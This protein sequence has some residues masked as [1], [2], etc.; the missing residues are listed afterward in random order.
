[1]SRPR[2]QGD[3]QMESK[4]IS[5]FLEKLGEDLIE[6]G[7]ITRSQL[8]Q[9]RQE[10]QESGENLGEV[11][12]R[13]GFSDQRKI[14]KYIGDGLDIPSIELTHYDIDPVAAETIE[15]SVAR[16]YRIIPMFEIE[17]VITI[18]MVDPFDIFAIEKMQGITGKIIEPVLATEKDVL[19]KIDLFWG[20]KNQLDELMD[21]LAVD[22]GSEKIIVPGDGDQDVVVD[23]RP[24]IKL[25]DSVFSDAVKK[26]ASD[27]H[28]EPESDLVRIRYRIDG[29]LQDISLVDYAY[30]AAMSTRV[31]YMAKMDIG[32]RRVPQDGKIHRSI[33][34]RKIDFRVST[35]PVVYGEKIVLRILDLKS[36]RVKLDDL[37]FDSE[38]LAD[39]R[40]VAR[41]SNG[42][43]LVTGPTGSG[44]TTTLYATLNEIKAEHLNITTIEDPVEY[45]MKG[46]SQGQVDVKAGITF[47]SALKAIVRQDPDVI[48][49]GEI[50][51]QE[52]AEL[53]IRAALTGH[54][55]FSTLHTNTAA[56]S[57][58][59]LLDMGLEPFLLASTIRGVLGQR[60]VRLI[61]K[62]C[63]EQYEPAKREYDLLGLDPGV[64]PHLFR[65]A[66]CPSCNNT[67]YKGRIGI[68][69]LLRMSPGIRDLVLEKAPD[70]GIQSEAVRSGMIMMRTDGARK[71]VK[72]LTTF[73]EVMR[74]T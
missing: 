71:V 26:G 31:K 51:D 30:H 36:V 33:G 19:T 21:E 69:E 65:G 58:S 53:A 10:K 67:G 50:R 70:T 44:K 57:V 73:D 11:L 47:A 38:V 64:I 72:G 18:A 25:V 14:N 42:V 54:L 20:E 16:K 49:V 59:R 55:V 62:E 52:T 60:L 56:G 74:V 32:Q 2:G 22:S 35:Y 28:I 12:V 4:V 3:R 1:M 27:I 23:D 9:A 68:Y 43:V 48:L 63:R 6:Q 7:A 15:E 34:G 24:I 5:I 8:E 29:V 13:L 66:G 17:D 40:E 39:Y 45:E 41:L 46:I 37:G 61:C